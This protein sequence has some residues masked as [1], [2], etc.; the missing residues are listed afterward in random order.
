RELR[1]RP[2][3]IPALHE[4]AALRGPRN[5]RRAH[6]GR[7]RP[8]REMA[9]R[10]GRSPHPHAPARPARVLDGKQASQLADGTVLRLA[11]ADRAFELAPGVEQEDGGGVVDEV[12][13]VVLWHPF[14]HHVP[15]RYCLFDLRRLAGDSDETPVQ[16]ADIV[17]QH[18][19]RV[20]LWID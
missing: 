9:A 13:A 4:A 10:R 18:R 5:P 3:R 16:P 17:L 11:I 1:A 19:G 8:C 7:P 2:A 12:A 14:G 15:G 20:A 6:L